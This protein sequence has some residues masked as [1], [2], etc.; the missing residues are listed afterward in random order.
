[1]L[2]VAATTHAQT[3]VPNDFTAGTPARAAEVNAN[4]DALEAAI[5]QNVSDIQAIPVGPQGEVGPQGPQ[6]IQGPQGLQGPQGDAGL[7]GPQGPQGA[8]GPEGPPGADLSNEVSILQGEQTVQ[9][10]RIDALEAAIAASLNENGR[11]SAQ[12]ETYDFITRNLETAIDE[13]GQ[14]YGIC[15]AYNISACN[16]LLGVQ[17]L[18]IMSALLRYDVYFVEDP[19]NQGGNSNFFARAYM[20]SHNSGNPALDRVWLMFGRQANFT[21]GA[22]VASA[23]VLVDSCDDP[24]IYLV[25]QG[26]RTTGG[27]GVD[28]GRVYLGDRISDPVPVNVTGGTYGLIHDYTK[29]YPPIWGGGPPPLCTSVSDRVGMYDSYALTLLV[30]TSTWGE[31]WALTANELPSP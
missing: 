15:S 8:I 10:D 12:L 20:K 6:G 3:Q 17:D 30:D 11:M 31:E 22:G 24:T 19:A 27:L 2:A 18:S 7:A 1:M 13:L 29:G 14:D 16:G 21:R 9:N 26:E 25:P 5:D 4:F 28:N 23:E